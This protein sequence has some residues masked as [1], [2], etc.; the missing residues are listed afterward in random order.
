MKPSIEQYELALVAL[1]DFLKASGAN[2]WAQ[3]LALWVTDLHTI[4]RDTS[5][6]CNHLHRSWFA[7]GGMGSLG[8]IT[9]CEENRNTIPP[10]LASFDEA[11]QSRRAL[12]ETLFLVTRALS[13]ELGCP[14]LSRLNR[15][16]G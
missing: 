3:R 5:A 13:A 12:V 2:A 16:V 1:R 11:N 8:D 7:T 15:P 10:H 4:S 9:L 14:P 6:L